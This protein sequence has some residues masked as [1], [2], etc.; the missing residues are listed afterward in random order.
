MSGAYF[1]RKEQNRHG[2]VVRLFQKCFTIEYS[3]E[4]NQVVCCRTRYRENCLM[5]VKTANTSCIE[6]REKGL[7]GRT[8][9]PTSQPNSHSCDMSHDTRLGKRHAG[10]QCKK[11]A[12]RAGCHAWSHAG[13]RQ[14]SP[15]A[16]GTPRPTTVTPLRGGGRAAPLAGRSSPPQPPQRGDKKDLQPAGDLWL[17]G[18]E[19]IA[20]YGG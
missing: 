20:S 2:Q 5:K 14:H 1:H 17:W 13:R 6:L 16:T 4:D 12:L 8:R 19:R 18:K 9:E 15:Q 7:V 10:A 3:E 11:R